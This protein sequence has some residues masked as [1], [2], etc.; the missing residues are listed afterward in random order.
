MKIALSGA[1]DLATARVRAKGK[2]SCWIC[3][4]SFSCIQFSVDLGC[5]IY[6]SFFKFCQFSSSLILLVFI[7]GIFSVMRE[8]FDSVLLSLTASVL[9]LCVHTKICTGFD[10][11]TG[12]IT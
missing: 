4:L 2:I 11:T 12:V 1:G 7:G 10:L 6:V 5:T 3:Q 9:I 8:S